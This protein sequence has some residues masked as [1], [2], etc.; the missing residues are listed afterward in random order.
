ML[1][2]EIY[3]SSKSCYIFLSSFLFSLSLFFL[4]SLSMTS[5]WVSLLNHYVA[6]DILVSTPSLSQQRR[7]LGDRPRLANQHAETRR[8]TILTANFYIQQLRIISFQWTLTTR[9]RERGQLDRTRV[10]EKIVL[11]YLSNTEAPLR[12]ATWV[13]GL[14]SGCAKGA[15]Y[16]P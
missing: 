10:R 16:S 7:D 2:P 6:L 15:A 8:H 9:T 5:V 1:F 14:F 13:R 4:K 12:F 11:F 3:K